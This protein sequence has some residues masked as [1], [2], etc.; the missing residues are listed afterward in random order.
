MRVRDYELLEQVWRY[1]VSIKANRP[2]HEMHESI[3]LPLA[4]WL[5]NNRPN[6][7]QRDV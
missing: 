3:Y 2:S 6:K 4:E 7:E 5:D 1:L